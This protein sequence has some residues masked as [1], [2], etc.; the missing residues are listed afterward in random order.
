MSSNKLKKSSSN[1]FDQFLTFC[2]IQ[3]PKIT[4]RSNPLKALDKNLI[5]RKNNNK[6]IYE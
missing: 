3:L 4:F 6:Y 5:N 2:G 1:V